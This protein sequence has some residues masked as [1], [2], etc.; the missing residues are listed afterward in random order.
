MKNTD[1]SVWVWNSKGYRVSPA[2]I[3]RNNTTAG[4]LLF[5]ARVP[6]RAAATHREVFE[7][8]LDARYHRKYEEMPEWRNAIE[9]WDLPESKRELWPNDAVVVVGP[10]GQGHIYR[11]RR[12]AIHD[13]PSSWT[14]RRIRRTR[15][16]PD[17]S[18]LPDD[19]IGSWL[20]ALLVSRELRWD[21]Y[22]ELALR[23]DSRNRGAGRPV[24]I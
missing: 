16:I 6:A 4:R 19:F 18:M 21:L 17:P 8:I 9:A 11:L 15:S 2:D 24:V 1:W 23:D 22:P 5:A 10:N 12:S 13:G 3:A 20:Y 7:G 14:C